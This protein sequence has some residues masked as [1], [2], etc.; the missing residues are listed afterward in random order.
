MEVSSKQKSKKASAFRSEPVNQAGRPVHIP[1][2]VCL[3]QR[4]FGFQ[5][6]SRQTTEGRKGNEDPATLDS[7][8]NS[9]LCVRVFRIITPKETAPTPA[10]PNNYMRYS[11]AFL[12]SRTA[13]FLTPH[14]IN[15]QLRFHILDRITS[16]HC[17]VRCLLIVR[18]R[19]L[20]LVDESQC[21]RTLVGTRECH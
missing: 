7:R 1:T 18:Q 21:K 3:I 15:S 6:M 8:A 4:Y 11:C 2:Y 17:I 16:M 9:L 13:Q 14:T 10:I 20:E 5:P 12:V 19:N